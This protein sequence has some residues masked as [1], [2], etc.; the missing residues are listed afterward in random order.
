MTVAEMIAELSKLPAY[1]EVRIYEDG[2]GADE[3]II[4]VQAVAR[5]TDAYVA[6][7]A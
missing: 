6:V 7:R 5:G 2:T 3:P 4:A 1:E